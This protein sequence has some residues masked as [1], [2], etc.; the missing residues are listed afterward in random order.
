MFEQAKPADSMMCRCGATFLILFPFSL[1]KDWVIPYQGIIEPNLDHVLA[2][3]AE[4]GFLQQRAW[5]R[6]VSTATIH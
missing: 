6:N 3:F 1:L 5:A 2:V 4:S